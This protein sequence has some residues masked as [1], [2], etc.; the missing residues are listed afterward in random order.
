[1]DSNVGSRNKAPAVISANSRDSST[2]VMNNML[3]SVQHTFPGSNQTFP[4]G[5]PV[6]NI[7]QRQPVPP[8]NVMCGPGPTY[9]ANSNLVG[10]QVT[11]VWQQGNRQPVPCIQFKIFNNFCLAPC[12]KLQFKKMSNYICKHILTCSTKLSSNCDLHHGK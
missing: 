12:E 5:P 10:R 3:Q 1:M 4:R 8:L 7:R 9:S 6:N 11:T 2:T